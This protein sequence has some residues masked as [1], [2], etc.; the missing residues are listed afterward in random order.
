MITCPEPFLLINFCR[1]AQALHITCESLCDPFLASF[2]SS[3]SCPLLIPAMLGSD[4]LQVVLVDQE[5]FQ[6]GM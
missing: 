2:G 1:L 6:G 5:P 4:Y 3:C